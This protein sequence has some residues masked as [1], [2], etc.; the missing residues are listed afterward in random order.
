MSQ[1]VLA[2]FYTQSG[3]LQDIIDNFTAPFMDAGIPVE[4]VMISPK[5][6]FPFPWSAE[7]FFDAMPES[8]LA[9]P[10][11]LESFQLRETA[12]DLVIFAYQPW[13]LSPS[14]PATSVLKHPS[15]IAVLK[16]TPVITLIGSRNMWLS[17]QER[18]KQLLKE[19]GAKLVGNIVLAD[20][21]NNFVSAVTMLHWMMGGKKDR[22]LNIFPKPGVSD[23]DIAQ[24]GVFGAIALQH[25]QTGNWSSLQTELVNQKAV[26]VKSDLMFVESRASRLFSIWAN[27]IIKKKNRKMWLV[28]FKY[29][30]LI[31]LFIVAPV[32]LLINNILFK[33]FLTGSINKK[34][35]YYLALN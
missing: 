22:Y 1:K 28:V 4:K 7:R 20:Q 14:I 10:G 9:I 31:A 17:A 21:H 25:L 15:L 2:I 8:V 35:Q 23:E 30:L 34:K 13:F 5:K 11:E 19:A 3:Q 33:P 16:N 29:Y 6:K 27:M 18:V 26:V 12:Y 24:T 32:V